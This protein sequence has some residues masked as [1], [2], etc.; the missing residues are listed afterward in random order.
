MSNK[1]LLKN[2]VKKIGED[3]ASIASDGVAS[4]ESG[5]NVDTGCYVFNAALSGSIYGGLFDN[6]ITCI[7]GEE[8]T[9]KTFFA[10]SILKYWME[11][12]P[13]G[14]VV[15]FDTEAAVTKDMFESRGLDSSRVVIVEPQT[16]E[17]FRTQALQI[18][19][20]YLD[21]ADETP[22]FFVLDSM[23]QLSSKK[24]LEDIASGN[25][26]RDMTKSQLLK[27]CFR[28]L[29]LKLAKANVPMIVTNHVYAIIGSMIPQKELSGGCLV[30][31][32]KVLCRTGY[33][34]IEEIVDGDLVFTKEGEW[35]DVLQTHTFDNKEI[36][37]IMLEN[38]HIIKC[39]G[40]HKF[41]VNG[42]WVETQNL[43]VD[44]NLEVV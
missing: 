6:K 40:E 36:Y 42:E 31:G 10:L 3:A 15:Y 34:N 16:I 4:A 19:N 17:D 26:K 13:E 32:T 39:T 14:V 2:I 18:V 9:G 28:V 25:D 21:S 5:G 38:G 41:F 7:A 44:D 35:C 33:K 12:N 30:K 20:D 37:E 29:N 1:T 27:A 24:E 22:M 23:G 8:S 11:Q 43:S